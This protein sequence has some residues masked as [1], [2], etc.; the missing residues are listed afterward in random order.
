MSEKMR[1]LLEDGEGN[2]LFMFKDITDE[3]FA[4]TA[5]DVQVFEVDTWNMDGTPADFSEYMSAYIKWDGC[6]NFS[7]PDDI[8]VHMCG[9]SQAELH[10]RAVMAVFDLAQCSIK[11]YDK[12]LAE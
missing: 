7:F 2:A 12:E 9:R 3:H 5:L 11:N 1:V 4:D 6:A 10:C 8:C